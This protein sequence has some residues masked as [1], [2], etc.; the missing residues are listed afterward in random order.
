MKQSLNRIIGKIYWGATVIGNI[1]INKIPSRNIRKFYYL[2]L[3]AKLDK[4][5]VVFRNSNII[6]PYK[7]KIGKGSSVGWNTFI[8]ARG[9]IVIGN[10]VTVASYCKLI[11]GSHDIDDPVFHAVFKPIVIEDY[12]WVCTGS[13]ILQ[14]VTIGKGSVVSAGS[15]VTKDVP[16]MTVVGGIPARKIRE[17]N[18]KP[19]F[20]DDLKWSWL[21]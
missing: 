6:S 11:T 19:T 3:G 17:R 20:Q 15:I 4:K 10:N 16:P 2:F 14:G 8:D 5:C 1:V 7:L 13:I 18:V 9:R 12:A 21:H